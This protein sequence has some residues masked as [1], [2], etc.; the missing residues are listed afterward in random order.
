M[1]ELVGNRIA[2]VGDDH[3]ATDFGNHGTH[4]IQHFPHGVV[5]GRNVEHFVEGHEVDAEIADQ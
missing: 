5:V 4:N 1:V 3:H 2:T